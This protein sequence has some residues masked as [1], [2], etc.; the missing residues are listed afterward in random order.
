MTEL[1]DQ[2][3]QALA[4]RYTI[5]RELGGGG[6]SRV[7]V[8][9]ETRFG[10]KVV[11]K[12]LA[13]ELAAGI[14]AERFEREIRLAASLQQAN[15]VPVLSAGE[16]NGLPYYTMPLVEGESLRARLRDH[17]ALPVAQVSSVLR[18][19]A[20]ALSYAH[21]PGVVHRD[22]KP[23]NILLSHGAAVVTDFGIAKAIAASQHPERTGAAGHATTAL[24]GLGTS[25]GTP[26]YMAPEQAAGDPATD[27]HADFYAFGCTAYELLAGHAPFHD[28][29]P[30]KLLTAHLNEPPVPI[31]T[32]RADTP[33][34]LAALIGRC[35][36]KDPLARPQSADELMA[37]LD[38]LPSGASQPAVPAIPSGVPGA[39]R[40]ALLIYTAALVLVA[41]IAKVAIVGVG[42][43]DWVFPG[44]L[45]VMALGLP[46]ILLTAYAQ[47]VTRRVALM[48]P[49]YTLTGSRSRAAHGTMATIALK[50]SPHLS[51]R[52]TTLGGV[53][54]IAA[55]IAIIGGFM[56]LRA[57]GIGP[58]ASLLAAGKLGK[59]D[60][61]IVSE[62]GTSR[63]DS[64]VGSVVAEATRA[65]LS[66]SSSIT[67]MSPAG[68]VG[69]LRRM[70]IPA[71][72][73]V[74]L[75]LARQIAAREGA[76]AIVTGDVTG[77]G[78]GFV[79]AVRL[80]SVDSGTILASFQTTVDGPKELISGVDEVSRKLR[81]KI[82]ESLKSVQA[83][84]PLAQ[85]T[86]ASLEALRLYTEGVRANNVDNDPA[87]SMQLFR[88]A[89]VLDTGFAGALR[90]LGTA[91][92]NI[93]SPASQRD[94]VYR[95]LYRHRDRLTETER[96]LADANYFMS[97]PGHDRVKAVAAYEHLLQRGDSAVALNNLGVIFEQRRD[98]ARAESLYSTSIRRQPG[99][100]IAFGNIFAA[101]N[102]QGKIAEMDAAIA[103]AAKLF[104]AM[105]SVSRVRATLPA[106]R[107]DYDR[108]AVVAE[109]L[110]VSGNSGAK[111]T[112]I[113][114][115]ATL[116]EL[117]GRLAASR[118]EWV[119]FAAMRTAVTG[120][121]PKP[122]LFDSLDYAEGD[123]WYLGPNE[124]SVQRVERVLAGADIAKLDPLDRP[125]IQAAR[126][127]AMAGRPERAR[128][129]LFQFPAQVR[130]TAFVRAAQPEVHRVLGEIAIAEKRPM[131]AV[132]EFR[133]ADVLPDGP[134]DDN[135]L[136]V[137]VDLGRAFDLAGR[138]DSAVV[139]FEKYLST[140]HFER[141]FTDDRRIAGVHKRLGELYEAEGNA[142]RAASHYAKFIELWSTADAELQPRVA[143]VK[144]RL[145]RLQSSERK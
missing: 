43:P 128:A 21:A 74:D 30:H 44:A 67:L 97:G 90:T 113:R 61:V 80:V 85:V 76:K 96:E 3:Q 93:G 36:E 141:L 105:N 68:V 65:N 2:L 35:M 45:A 114:V 132:V 37:M 98:Y 15:I 40:R 9:D 62:F 73:R 120:E 56:M 138:S 88:Q 33:A 7:F 49:A 4:D 57:L 121:V 81:G 17:G 82:G 53:Y 118:R 6:M 115:E 130:D 101:L 46:G 116:D 26:A 8:A 126:V 136:P 84:P 140:P 72:S 5:E 86:T 19:V 106:D 119:Q 133:R 24:T 70:Q 12:V 134:V 131:D 66:Q 32:L 129:V 143:D 58:A 124:R 28:L 22:I 1:R 89:L 13:P 107:G 112:G 69:A 111:R 95:A 144:R 50:A 14:S 75:A 47:R 18:D 99:A 79:I 125:Y 54:A 39:F 71:T 108:A 64:S 38:A 92:G 31:E 48:T 110:R 142:A 59:R 122:A 102:N 145:A 42:L 103:R 11:V 60:L 109:S 91:M 77:L 41:L 87:K 127:F 100:A 23:D 137:L 123:A 29:P 27:H 51:W 52:R 78:G 135:P 20:R 25:I 16:T 104:P 34:G 94:S 83:S 63:A 139:Y 117:H 55:F 10:R